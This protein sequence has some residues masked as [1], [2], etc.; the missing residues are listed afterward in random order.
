MKKRKVRITNTG[1]LPDSPD[2]NN[3][4]NIIPSNQ[5][6]MKNVP[7]PILGID[8]M[9][10]R[11][12]MMPGGEYSFPGQ[13]VTEIPMGKYQKGKEVTSDQLD[14]ALDAASFIPGYVGMGASAIG[15][16][17]NLAEGDYT[18]AALD[19]LNII[20]GG[21][22]KWFRAAQGAAKAAGKSRLAKSAADKARLLEIASNPLVSKTLGLGRDVYNYP[23]D[24][25][26]PQ[27]GRGY[28]NFAVPESTN[29]NPVIREPLLKNKYQQ[30]GGIYMGDYDFKDGGLVK[31]VD[32]GKST[33]NYAQAR[34][35]SMFKKALG[36]EER[37]ALQKPEPPL[38]NMNAYLSSKLPALGRLKEEAQQKE[39]ET[40]YSKSPVFQ[41]TRLLYNDPAKQV[42]DY[43]KS[44]DY[45]LRFKDEKDYN[46]E[47]IKSIQNSFKNSGIFQSK[48]LDPKNYKT[49]E[50]VIELQKFLAQ[51][52]LMD[53]LGKYGKNKDGID[54]KLGKHTREA[55][56]LYNEH[57]KPY[58]EGVLDDPTK[59]AIRD[60]K[61]QAD[62]KKTLGL[63]V[64]D[65]L[66]QF[67]T[68]EGEANISAATQALQDFESQLNSKGYFKGANFKTD[69]IKEFNPRV[70]F[71]FKL[72]PDSKT[73]FG[74]C[75]Q[76]VNGTICDEDAAGFD[77]REELGLSGSAWHISD[78]IQSKGGKSIFAGLPQ[79]DQVPNLKT[80]D[81]I[82]NYIKS[83]LNSQKENL[84]NIVK[85]GVTW[86]SSVKP[87]DVVNIF[88][89]GSNYTEEAYNQTKSLNNRLFTTHVGVVK[90]DDNGNLFVEHNVHGKVEKDKLTDFLEG[91][92]KGN[93]KNKVSM[94]SG[95]TR[96][97]YYMG[98]LDDGS[99]IPEQGITYYQTEYGKFNPKGAKAREQYDG[100]GE[101]VSNKIT[102]KFL[103][104]IENNRDQLLKDI[105]ISENEF[106]KLMRVSRAIPTLETYGGKLTEE[107]S[108]L[109][110]TLQD[111]FL[112][113]REKSMGI[114][115]LKDETNLGQNLRSKLITSDYELNKPEK[116]AIPTF[117]KISK[118][119]LY[120]KEIANKNGIRNITADQLAKLAGLSYN[121][122]VGKIAKD[123]VDA[124]SYD[125]Y[126]NNRKQQAS[127]LGKSQFRYEGLVDVYDNQ[128]MKRG[129]GV[130]DQGIYLGK[131]EFKDGGLVKYQDKGEVNTY[132]LERR[133][134]AM[135]HNSIEDYRNA[136]WGYGENHPKIVKLR[137]EYPYT[138]KLAKGLPSVERYKDV[139]PTQWFDMLDM[140][141]QAESKNKNIRQGNNGPGRG[142]Y[143]FEAPSTTT[144]KNRAIQI[145]KDLNSLGY[146]LQVPERFDTNFMN[147]SKDEQ[148]FYTLSNLIK[149]ASAKR[150]GN[151]NY[152]IDLTNPGKAWFDL[153]WAGAEKHPEDV[154]DRIAHWNESN[155]NYKIAFDKNGELLPIKGYGGLI[156]AQ[157][158]KEYKTP[159]GQ[160]IYL[161]PDF[162]TYAR[163]KDEN[164]N[165]IP[166]TELQK[167]SMIYDPQANT[168]D[169]THSETPLQVNERR[170]N[171]EDR[172]NK[173]L[174]NPMDK[175]VK[176]AEGLTEAGEDPI[177]NIRHP[178][179]G[180]YTAQAIAKKT[181]NIP[182]ISPALGWLGSN[183]MG[184][185]HELGTIMQDGRPLKQKGREALEDIFNNN[186]GATMSLMPIPNAAKEEALF[187]MSFN[188][189]LPD[190]I[191]HP[192]GRDFYFKKDGGSVRKVKIKRAPR[193]NQ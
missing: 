10:N 192:E 159:T 63:R 119:Y 55:I 41:S 47:D 186:A 58:K 96:P 56:R 73:P 42:A 169:S 43:E 168:W 150:E 92:V 131:Y 84:K 116:A 147:L 59:K 36:L 143:Q 79:R 86:D 16:L 172:V 26:N 62:A 117:Y 137:Q 21:T 171:T 130:K 165:V 17:K 88:Y 141:A 188:N 83:N 135:G 132:E 61:N 121:Q 57:N 32:G 189:K 11:Q 146:D 22:S 91:K 134:K 183:A 33:T 173:W 145:K 72:N 82:A 5:I 18:G 54:G 108:P 27:Y 6:T 53:K 122:S 49:E 34:Q 118:D 85:G 190:G 152:K 31:L 77:A 89:E 156:K 3:P 125:N 140:I 148:A 181:G 179:A 70:A 94:I 167:F 76:Y 120:L 95:I 182:Y 37:I 110:K 48:E 67:I 68:P 113:D 103:K 14:L 175:A 111:T 46:E 51:N 139:S 71:K 19:G 74:M 39:V 4:M 114:T 30:G 115:K 106:D 174:G 65:D 87:G 66:N 170:L 64:S 133:A 28:N 112:P 153:H 109:Q 35:E 105:P 136:N 184:I 127:S 158:G 157:K 163:Y 166:T 99:G 40:K 178:L 23:F 45:K 162:K 193:K 15:G 13:Y 81:E 126:I 154:N 177:D 2:R 75:A 100:L 185:G 151:P 101:S 78:N 164:G 191:V 8:N 160:S 176:V 60:F 97:N 107:V 123:L 93:G 7:F 1:Y 155:P 25:S 38:S 52:G 29:R 104:T 24:N 138:W 161:D 9:G 80:K 90:A 98:A 180:L 144:A 187:Q 142:Y 69:E 44:A 20:T 128:T 149:G 124:G 129:G 102:Y 50:E 12:M